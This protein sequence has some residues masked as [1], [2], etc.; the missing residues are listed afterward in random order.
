MS[1]PGRGPPFGA[2]AGGCDRR[3]AQ[4]REHGPAVAAWAAALPGARVRTFRLTGDDD[5]P[6]PAADDRVAVLLV[7]P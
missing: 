4:A 5:L 3:R 6:P 7:D 1:G 2:T